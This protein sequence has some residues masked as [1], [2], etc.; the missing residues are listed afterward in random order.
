[1]LM[2]VDYL[3]SLSQ[4][5]PRL[6]SM[7]FYINLLFLAEEKGEEPEKKENQNRPYKVVEAC[8]YNTSYLFIFTR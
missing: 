2:L 4:F 1:M 8:F 7:L 6:S 3:F 5:K